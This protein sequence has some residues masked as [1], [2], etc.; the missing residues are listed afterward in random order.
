M[1]NDETINQ[2]RKAG[3]LLHELTEMNSDIPGSAWISAMMRVIALSFRTS[4]ASYEDYQSDIK[5]MS[6]F[7]KQLW[8]IKE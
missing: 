2:A 6:E 7:Y 5:Q 8:E 4:D 3:Q 1:N